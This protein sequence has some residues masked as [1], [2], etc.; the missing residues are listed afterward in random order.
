MMKLASGG[1]E[2]IYSPNKTS[3]LT[4]DELKEEYDKITDKTD[5]AALKI[6]NTK[7]DVK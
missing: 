1:I 3:P 4:E 7:K 6:Y 5:S 2:F